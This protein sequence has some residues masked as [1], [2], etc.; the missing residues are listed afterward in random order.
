VQGASL[1]GLL[2]QFAV[3]DIGAIER[4]SFEDSQPLETLCLAEDSTSALESLKEFLSG[5]GIGP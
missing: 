4:R 5:T 2:R 3:A 1:S